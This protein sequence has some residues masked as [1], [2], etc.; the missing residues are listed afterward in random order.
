MRVWGLGILAIGALIAILQGW[1][2]LW[3]LFH[4]AAGL[5]LVGWLS[6]MA[7]LGLL[8]GRRKAQ[9]RLRVGLGTMLAA[10]GLALLAVP[11]DG[12][13]LLT[14]LRLGYGGALL[15]IL[16]HVWRIHRAR[17]TRESETVSLNVNK[18]V[19]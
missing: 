9:G 3:P 12:Q 11:Q 6:G 18:G 10:L 8:V 7:G 5:A 16:P 17:A 19:L 13:G 14:G 1:H 4:Q 15:A 2:H